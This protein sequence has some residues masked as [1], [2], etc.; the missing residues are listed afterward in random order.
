M[1]RAYDD[2]RGR[3]TSHRSSRPAPSDSVDEK[4]DNDYDDDGDGDKDDEDSPDHVLPS[5]AH[6]ERRIDGRG[7]FLHE[8]SSGS[9]ISDRPHSSAPSEPVGQKS[10][11]AQPGDTKG[12]ETAPLS[13][14]GRNAATTSRTVSLPMP[15][16]MPP[17]VVSEGREHPDSS[18]Q[19][20]LRVSS[21]NSFASRGN[22]SVTGSRSAMSVEMGMA[23]GV[24][25]R[26]ALVI[27][28]PTSGHQEPGNSM[29]SCPTATS[30]SGSSRISSSSHLQK[31]DAALNWTAGD[32]ATCASDS[33]L[34]AS[35]VVCHPQCTRHADLAR[36]AIPCEVPSLLLRADS[37]KGVPTS[38]SSF[39]QFDSDGDEDW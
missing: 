14:S 17:R 29:Q 15:I 35:S 16:G 34:S 22:L 37:A 12:T 19:G 36:G 13:Y 6:L 28:R 38:A 10:L 23:M 7:N 25:V 1:G 24:G 39:I 9:W 33:F 31:V 4:D 30:G 8:R 2:G 20:P 21:F 27:K 26:A 18:R 5:T 3:V 11:R 32:T